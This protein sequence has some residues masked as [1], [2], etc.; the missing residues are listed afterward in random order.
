MGTARKI[1]IRAQ[2]A[3]GNSTTIE[4]TLPE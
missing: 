2:D 1:E 3:A 4:A